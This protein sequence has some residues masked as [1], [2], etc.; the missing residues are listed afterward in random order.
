[1]EGVSAEMGTAR[2]HSRIMSAATPTQSLAS[3]PPVFAKHG[4]VAR[5]T[6]DQLRVTLGPQSGNLACLTI[7]PGSE[8]L[9][10]PVLGEL[11]TAAPYVFANLDGVLTYQYFFRLK[12]SDKSRMLT[13]R[14]NLQWTG[15]VPTWPT[16]GYRLQLGTFSA[17]PTLTWQDYCRLTEAISGV[18]SMEA[19]DPTDDDPPM[20]S[21]QIGQ[22]MA[23]TQDNVTARFEHLHKDRF[24]YCDAWGKWF[25]WD[26]SY[27]YTDRTLLAFHYS[28]M[29]SRDMNEKSKINAATASFAR[30][31]EFLARTSRSFATEPR[32]WDRNSWL[33]NTPRA[34][35][36]LKEDTSWPHRQSDLIT[37]ITRVSPEDG[38]HPIFDRFIRDITLE[39]AALA[40]YLQI[41]LGA[42]LSGAIQ[43]NFVL[44]W[45]GAGQ[46]GKNTLGDLICWILGDYAKVI[47]PDTLISQKQS[48]GH[49]TELANLRGI[50][51]AICS[52]IAEGS[53]W[54]E[55]RIKSLSGDAQIS[56]R[57]MHQDLFEFDRTHKHLIYGNNRPMLRIVDP[58]IKSRLHI[59][60]FKA[61]F[62]PEARDPQM[63]QKLRSEAPQILQWLIDGH[64]LWLESGYLKKCSAVQEETD[65]YFDAQ[66]TPMMWVNERCSTGGDDLSGGA[67]MLYKNFK[68]W[69][70]QRGEGAMSQS[71]WGEWMT[72]AG[73][74]KYKSH[75]TTTYRGIELKPSYAMSGPE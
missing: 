40:Q 32:D 3:Y 71:R 56:A 25:I 61:H 66:S 19:S 54:D 74:R 64:S 9:S 39:D 22:I 7:T 49:P 70:E 27:W 2:H 20:T 10:L 36:D 60:P 52:E 11:L 8:P 63:A 31:V 57:F 34:T 50:R 45:F 53:Y 26:K 62:P 73:Y 51:L 59:V 68:E 55:V 46:N 37:K 13:D 16:P 47:P 24:R 29:L 75:G 18:P 48:H 43:D 72:S 58:A 44:F 33:L 69:K 23:L 6:D 67:T 65:S 35:M 28:R 14:V 15:E 5:V 1:M 42:C 38:P 17:V 30:G 21:R 4:I 12:D 41:S